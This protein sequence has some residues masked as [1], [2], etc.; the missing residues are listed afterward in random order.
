MWPTGKTIWAS[1]VGCEAY[2]CVEWRDRE[3]KWKW[4]RVNAQHKK[5]QC[6]HLFGR[7]VV[8]V[9][10]VVIVVSDGVVRTRAAVIIVAHIGGE[11]DR[12][13]L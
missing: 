5:R 6:S 1:F 13:V 11:R 10:V 3:W 12:L 8:F 2:W 7:L 9:V 4:S